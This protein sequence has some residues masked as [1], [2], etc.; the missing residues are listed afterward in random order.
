[1]T[2]TYHTTI[3]PGA[4]RIIHHLTINGEY[5]TGTVTKELLLWA[6]PFLN[7][8]QFKDLE[9]AFRFDEPLTI[10]TDKPDPVTL[11]LEDARQNLTLLE[12]LLRR[13]GYDAQAME[14]IDARIGKC[15]GVIEKA[16]KTKEV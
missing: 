4:L 11:L 3:K 7:R 10:N 2:L 9:R 5:R 15:K 16:T 13:V 14:W 12:W 8:D 1:M 6:R